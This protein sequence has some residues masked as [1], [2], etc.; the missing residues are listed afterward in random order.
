MDVRIERIPART[1]AEITTLQETSSRICA[2]A[3]VAIA[4]WATVLAALIKLAFQNIL[5]SFSY[6]ADSKAAI[7]KP[8][9]PPT[10][11]PIN[12]TIYL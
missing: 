5:I 4:V 10:I 1:D 9:F 11:I 2:D 6:L 3:I 8:M 12:K 7:K